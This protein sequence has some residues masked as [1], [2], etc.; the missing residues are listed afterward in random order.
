MLAHELHPFPLQIFCTTIPACKTSTLPEI[1][2]I[3]QFHFSR[4]RV[5]SSSAHH[6]ASPGM[7]RGTDEPPSVPAT[8]SFSQ[9]QYQAKRLTLTSASLRLTLF[10]WS[11]ACSCNG[12]FLCAP[13]GPFR[14][15]S[16]GR[17]LCCV[18]TW[19]PFSQRGRHCS[20]EF[21]LRAWKAD[22]AGN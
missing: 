11:R 2:S 5:H 7:A 14:P 12:N 8:H 10:G 21:L 18:T 4:Y 3:V 6:R 22:Q 17:K 16:K 9:E 13:A 1:I 15:I 20:L 19:G